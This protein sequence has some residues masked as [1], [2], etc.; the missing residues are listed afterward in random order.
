VAGIVVR[1]TAKLGNS[2]SYDFSPK[3]G[4][5]M[6]I[7]NENEKIKYKLKKNTR[8]IETRRAVKTT[9]IV[10]SSKKK[11][12]T[13]T[14][15]GVWVQRTGCDLNVTIHVPARWTRR[16]RTGDDKRYTT[17]DGRELVVRRGR[18]IIGRG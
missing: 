16:T 14:V 11:K 2:Y 12:R 13:K 5:P 9:T 4:P 1:L 10:I 8:M 15:N 6:R 18:I 7:A 17:V 3:S